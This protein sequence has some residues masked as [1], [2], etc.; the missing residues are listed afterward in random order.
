MTTSIVR[1]I[2]SLHR[3]ISHFLGVPLPLA[4]GIKTRYANIGVRREMKK[5]QRKEMGRWWNVCPFREIEYIPC[6]IKIRISLSFL[7]SI[8]SLVRIFFASCEFVLTQGSWLFHRPEYY[9]FFVL[10]YHSLL[11]EFSL[12]L[13]IR[14]RHYAKTWLWYIL[15]SL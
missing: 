3:L 6:L 15:K 11:D 5:P 8:I 14:F 13:I 12:T 7:S 1:W 2:F 4:L 9:H 10:E